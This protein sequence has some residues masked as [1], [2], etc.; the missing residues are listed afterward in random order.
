MTLLL[1]CTLNSNRK[2]I[3]QDLHK[4]YIAI[5]VSDLEILYIKLLVGVHYLE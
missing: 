1:F 2:F 5:I 4:L 3:S